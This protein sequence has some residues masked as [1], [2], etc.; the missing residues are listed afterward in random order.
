MSLDTDRKRSL[1]HEGIQAARVWWN[2]SQA[3]LYEEAVRRREGL[4]AADGPLVC[5][6]GQHTGRSPQ[7]KF[8]VREPSSDAHIAWGA[9]NRPLDPAS[10]NA[11]KG[12]LVGSLRNTD[13]YVFDC[14][15]G[16]DPTYRVPVR[17]IT[18]YAWHSL[19]ARNLLIVDE[20]APEVIPQL[21]IIDAPSF[22]ADPT[23]HGTRSEVVVALNFA[24]R[25]VLIGGTSY[26]GEIKKSVFST[27]NYLLPFRGVMPMHCSANVGLA[28]D[29]AL[30]FGLSGTGKTTLSSDPE[31]GLIGD[32]E[33]GWGDRGVFNFEGG[34]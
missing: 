8:I 10:F 18:E 3:A 2:L 30:F 32:D 31:R 29:V 23:R 11:L 12:D 6:T 25:L 28:G 20:S 26:A 7:D 27:M 14:F 15:A 1:E 17:V 13:V 5:R 16:A 34:C 4:I 19:F 33:H 24:E 22:K 21:T 9:S